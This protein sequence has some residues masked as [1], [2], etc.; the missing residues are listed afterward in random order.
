MR[1]ID[2]KDSEEV[3][4]AIQLTRSE[5][6]IDLI[7]HTPGGLV[8]AAGQIAN[9]LKRS[10]RRRYRVRAALRD[11]GRHAD[12]A[13]RR[14]DRD[15]LQRGAGSGRS[16]A[17][18]HAGRLDLKVLELKKPEDIE[19]QTLILADIAARRA[20]RWRPSC[21]GAARSTCPRT[22]RSR[23]PPCSPRG[24]GRTT[25]RSRWRWPGARPAHRHRDA[26][27]GLR[28]DGPLS[29]GRRGPALRAVRSAPPG[30]PE[31][32]EST[33][34]SPGPPVKGRTWR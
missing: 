15:G 16:A 21:R 26:A 4:R 6:P 22:R 7:V 25:S 24:G 31:R 18:R 34:P 11:V 30:M 27:H 14:R 5:Q 19:D 3:L 32:G 10:A 28:P 12:R 29:A 17:R 23:S 20:C 2:V 33:T 1:Y 8:L 9:A 13:G